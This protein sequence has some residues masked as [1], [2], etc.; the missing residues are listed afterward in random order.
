MPTSVTIPSGYGIATHVWTFIASGKQMTV[1]HGYNDATALDN[2]SDAANKLY[3]YATAVGAPCNAPQ[4]TADWRY[5]GVRVLQ[6]LAGGVLQA[7]QKLVPITGTLA[8]ATNLSPVFTTFVVS[9]NTLFAGRAYRGR[10][11]VPF[12][13]VNEAAVDFNGTILAANVTSNQTLWTGYIANI[14]AGLL[15]FMYLLHVNPPV[16]P[17]LPPTRVTSLTVRGVVGLQRRRRIRGA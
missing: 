14:N 8:A 11:Y 7:G 9:K 16:G 5:E 4:M 6:R 13:N 15:Y 1:T 12:L 3:G 10:M 17:A 2:P